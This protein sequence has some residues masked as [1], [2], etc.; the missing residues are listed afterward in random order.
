MKQFGNKIKEFFK[1]NKFFQFLK[2][3]DNIEVK[4]TGEDYNAVLTEDGTVDCGE[5]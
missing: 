1:K 2:K 5:Y 4:E 3:Y